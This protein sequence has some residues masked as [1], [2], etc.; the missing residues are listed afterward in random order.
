MKR[1]LMLV[2]MV[3]GVTNAAVVML[4]DFESYADDA[5]L[6][7]AWVPNESSDISDEKL[8]ND[9]SVPVLN[10]NNCMLVYSEAQGV[11]WIQTKLALPGAVHNDHGV[12][13]TYPG[14]TAITMTFAIPPNGSTPPYADLGGSGGN[15]LISMF[16]CWGQNVFSANYSPTSGNNV[17]PSGT[18]WSTGIV[19][20]P[21]FATYTKAGM[22]LENVEHITVGYSNGWWGEGALFVDDI[23]FVV[24]EPATLTLLALGGV[25]LRRKK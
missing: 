5:A 13:L 8:I 2:L 16:D 4:D 10:G 19:W 7:A 12:N 25:L 24:P 9:S 1:Y 14:Y 15:V 11:G 18:G 17:T 23:G 22:N 21:D 20:A 6:Q 3:V